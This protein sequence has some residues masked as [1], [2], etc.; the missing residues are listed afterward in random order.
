MPPPLECDITDHE[1]LYTIFRH[2]NGC[3]KCDAE[4]EENDKSIKQE[5]QGLRACMHT[6]DFKTTPFTINKTAGCAGCNLTELAKPSLWD[7]N[8]DPSTTDLPQ[9]PNIRFREC[10]VC[11][12]TYSIPHTKLAKCSNCKHE[13]SF[14]N[15]VRYK[16]PI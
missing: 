15:K 12:H 4:Q 14:T 7:V 11:D 16:D 10:S 2:K 8:F 9:E 1:R 5:Y 13:L 3:A 6:L